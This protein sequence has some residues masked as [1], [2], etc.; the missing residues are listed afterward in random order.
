MVEV[1]DLSLDHI[2]KYMYSIRLVTEVPI[3]ILRNRR[4]ARL[5]ANYVIEK[6]ILQNS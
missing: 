1:K 3:S 6:S 2:G 5:T 4:L